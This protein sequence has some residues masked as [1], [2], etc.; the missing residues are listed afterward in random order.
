MNIPT[1]EERT[2]R[3]QCAALQDEIEALRAQRAVLWLVWTLSLFCGLVL[4]CGGAA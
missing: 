2:L 3:A 4:L 1:N